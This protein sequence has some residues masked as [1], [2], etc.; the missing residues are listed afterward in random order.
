MK[1]YFAVLI[2]LCVVFWSCV[3]QYSPRIAPTIRK[4][5]LSAEVARCIRDRFCHKQFVVAHRSKGFGALENSLSAVKKAAGTV[6]IIEIDIHFSKDKKLIVM[7]NSKID[8]TT[9]SR[10]RIKDMDSNEL[11]AIKLQNGESVP[12]FEAI[13]K[14]SRGKSIL[15]LDFKDNAVE[16][17]AEWIDKNGSFDDVIFFVNNEKEMRSAAKIK[18]IYPAV[19]VMARVRNFSD[20]LKMVIKIFSRIPEVIHTSSSV[21]RHQINKIHG[22][23]AKVF[24]NALSDWF[25]MPILGNILIRR[26]ISIKTDF[27]QTDYPL[28]VLTLLN[29]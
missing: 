14:I 6:P 11:K 29:K 24:A 1:K 20:D 19:M 16:Q 27:I 9:V 8:G 13:Y 10:G 22:L 18:K 2:L 25:D 21:Y 5:F 12:T 4:T 3:S 15:D 23:G 26:L 28:Y 17:V 7:H